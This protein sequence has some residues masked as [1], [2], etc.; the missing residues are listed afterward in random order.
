MRTVYF[1]DVR[2]TTCCTQQV[3]LLAMLGITF[4]DV[5]SGVTD[6]TVIRRCVS[7]EEV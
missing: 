3:D 2:H 7:Q 6:R 1:A 4:D 5:K